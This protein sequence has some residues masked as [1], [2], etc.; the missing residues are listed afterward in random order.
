MGN[1]W[2]DCESV[3]CMLLSRSMP[4]RFNTLAPTLMSSDAMRDAEMQKLVCAHPIPSHPFIVLS[5]P[6]WSS[7]AFLLKSSELRSLLAP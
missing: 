3:I 2:G 4:S 5:L 7:A 6:P 1:I